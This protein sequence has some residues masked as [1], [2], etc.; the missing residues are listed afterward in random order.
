MDSPSNTHTLLL[1]T[2]INKA[3]LHAFCDYHKQVVPLKIRY[4]CETCRHLQFKKGTCDHCKQFIDAEILT[5]PR[6]ETIDA[7]LD[8]AECSR[9]G[10][11]GCNECEINC[12]SVFFGPHT[13]RDIF[14]M[15]VGMCA[16]RE[17][18]EQVLMLTGKETLSECS[19]EDFVR[20]FWF[21]TFEDFCAW[22]EC[23]P[24]VHD[25]FTV[26]FVCCY[27]RTLVDSFVFDRE[28]R[29]GEKREALLKFLKRSLVDF[30][31]VSSGETDEERDHRLER[32][33]F[34]YHGDYS[35]M[36]FEEKLERL[37]IEIENEMVEQ[38]WK[39]LVIQ[40]E[41]LNTLSKVLPH[42][43]SEMTHSH[44]NIIL[45]NED[46]EIVAFNET[47][48]RSTLMEFIVG[49][50]GSDLKC[51]RE[52]VNG[53]FYFELPIVDTEMDE[54]LTLFSTLGVVLARS[55]LEKC[56]LPFNFCS[57]GWKFL[58][59]EPVSC[60][61]F[62]SVDPDFYR[63]MLMMLDQDI[64]DVEL[65]FAYEYVDCLQQ[66]SF[67][68]LREDPNLPEGISDKERNQRNIDYSQSI[69]LDDE[70]KF[71]YCRRLIEWRLHKAVEPLIDILCS[72]FY[73]ALPGKVKEIV[74]SL[75]ASQLEELICGQREIDVQEW[76]EATTQYDPE[77]VEEWLWEY[78]E[79]NPDKRFEVLYFTTSLLRVPYGGIQDLDFIISIE[80]DTSN[81][82]P[83]ARACTHELIL[84]E[85]YDSKEVFYKKMELALYYKKNFGFDY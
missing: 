17:L 24:M 47:A 80:F 42:S 18:I 50:C 59:K 82:V 37:S 12:E 11:F 29:D 34:A 6:C 31:V 1:D 43:Y 26:A 14:R 85:F 2:P 49:F 9:R 15:P 54:L 28:E 20:S 64:E 23:M 38:E 8:C 21:E 84:S 19:E 78:L 22:R 52:S 65:T 39:I 41:E 71:D 56:P 67:I 7:K 35:V 58:A 55:I 32:Q 5:C 73:D 60:K 83:Q 63:S 77:Q 70:N 74:S 25:R 68:P 27:C 45:F 44:F 53:N 3:P 81:R 51:M 48:I 57:V 30:P 76:R 62:A 75:T 61:D 46:G 13:W 66:H 79:D 10:R 33:S 36:S 69:K 40:S 16:R 4:G 72:T